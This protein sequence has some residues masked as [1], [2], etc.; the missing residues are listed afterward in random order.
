MMVV[1]DSGDA[2]GTNS[3]VGSSV[4]ISVLKDNIGEDVMTWMG[5]RA[6]E[7]A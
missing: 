4:G 5:G 2:D 3:S 6:R 7:G 1:L